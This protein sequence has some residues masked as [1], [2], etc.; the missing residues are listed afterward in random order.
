MPTEANHYMYIL[1]GEGWDLGEGVK[2]CW[3]LSEALL[4][5]HS[6][7]IGMTCESQSA[8]SSFMGLRGTA[9]NGFIFDIILGAYLNSHTEQS[10]SG[11]VIRMNRCWDLGGKRRLGARRRG[12]LLLRIGAGRRGRAFALLCMGLKDF[13]SKLLQ[14]PKNDN[15]GKTY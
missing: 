14:T 7:M 11:G 6:G 1:R 10:T 12:G 9:R 15:K 2:R 3:R 13:C 5:R 8:A 4:L